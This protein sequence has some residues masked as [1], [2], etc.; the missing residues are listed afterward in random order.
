MPASNALDMLK[1]ASHNGYAVGAFNV[2]NLVQFRAVVEEASARRAPVIVQT[3]VT[4]A[5]FHGAPVWVAI[6]RSIAAAAPVPVCLHLDHCPDV[7]FCKSCSDAGYTNIS[8][9]RDEYNPGWIDVAVN[10]AIRGTVGRWMEML[11]CSGKA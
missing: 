3:S 4:P 7:L 5:R 2:T 11:G 10:D 6:Y 1:K 9:N 8:S